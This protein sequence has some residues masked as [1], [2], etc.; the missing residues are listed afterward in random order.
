M[1]FVCSVDLHEKSYPLAYY[2][3]TNQMQG[4]INH[5]SREVRQFDT[6][7]ETQRQK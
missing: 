4:Q 2:D 3:P 6:E 7:T 5:D 1:H